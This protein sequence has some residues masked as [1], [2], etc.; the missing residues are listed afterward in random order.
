MPRNPKH[1]M[2]VKTRALTRNPKAPNQKEMQEWP[3]NKRKIV[4]KDNIQKQKS[5]KPKRKKFKTSL[6]ATIVLSTQPICS[7]PWHQRTYQKKEKKKECHAPTIKTKK[8]IEAP[9][10]RQRRLKRCRAG[11]RRSREEETHST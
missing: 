9:A 8:K 3:L 7:N 4:E 10:R 2:L 6:P 1:P 5:P 11:W